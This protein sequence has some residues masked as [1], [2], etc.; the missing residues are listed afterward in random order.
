VAQVIGQRVAGLPGPAREL[1]S[2][3]AVAGRVVPHALLAEV[4]GRG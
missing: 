2:V 3:A 4:T 1:V